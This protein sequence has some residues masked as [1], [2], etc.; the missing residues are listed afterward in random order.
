MKQRFSRNSRQPAV[1]P[2]LK[3]YGGTKRRPTVQVYLKDTGKMV[4]VD[5]G[6]F[7]PGLHERVDIARAED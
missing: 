1:D 2:S 5:A 4:T 3:I 7:D 6:A